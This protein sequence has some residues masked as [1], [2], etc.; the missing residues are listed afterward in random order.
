MIVEHARALPSTPGMK[1]TRRDTQE[2]KKR[3]QRY[4]LPGSIHS[5]QDSQLVAP[6]PADELG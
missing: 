5:A 4:V 1:P 2:P 3:S 6:R